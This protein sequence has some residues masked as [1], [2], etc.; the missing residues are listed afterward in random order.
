MG[1]PNYSWKYLDPEEEGSSKLIRNIIN[2]SPID[3]AP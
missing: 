1:S 3:T 2:G